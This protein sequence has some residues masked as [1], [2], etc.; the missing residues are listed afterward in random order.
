MDLRGG[1]PSIHA[2][3]LE[4]LVKIPDAEASGIAKAATDD[5]DETVRAVA[6]SK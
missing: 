4:R 5:A 3:A 6:A 2:T 1:N